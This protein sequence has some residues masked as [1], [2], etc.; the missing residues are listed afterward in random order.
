MLT[1]DNSTIG[2]DEEELVKV[3]DSIKTD[4]VDH[5]IGIL[6]NGVLGVESSI[7]D[8]WVGVSA[9]MF[10]R[11]MHSDLANVTNGLNKAY[12]MFE[13]TAREILSD[14]G[15]VDANVVLDRTGGV[16]NAEN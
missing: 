2:F 4:I 14:M 6:E 11:N 9:D 7:K 16:D 1:I 5:A 13:Y 10:I 8:A 15:E 3:I 12:E